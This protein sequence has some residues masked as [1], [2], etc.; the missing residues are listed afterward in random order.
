MSD[1]WTKAKEL[2]T[3]TEPWAISMRRYLHKTPELS[4]MEFSTA[5]KIEKELENMGIEFL[6]WV[7]SLP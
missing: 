6:R 3:V 7:L 1:L 4:G 2:I 5:A